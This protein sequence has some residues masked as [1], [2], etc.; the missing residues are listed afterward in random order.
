MPSQS[1][2]VAE[3]GDSGFSDSGVFDGGFSDLGF[4]DSEKFCGKIGE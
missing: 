2:V 4:S 3:S 1:A